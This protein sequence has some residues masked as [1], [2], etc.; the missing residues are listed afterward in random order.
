MSFLRIHKVA[1]YCIVGDK[2]DCNPRVFFPRDL[3]AKLRASLS[4]I[5]D[6]KDILATHH[7]V[8][9]S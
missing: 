8:M 4:H 2:N 1:L 5:R 3:S 7:V 6:V 9:S